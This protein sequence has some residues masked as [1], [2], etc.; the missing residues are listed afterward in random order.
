VGARDKGRE[1]STY[2]WGS[3]KDSLKLSHT[4]V[5]TVDAECTFYFGCC[6]EGKKGVRDVSTD[7][8]REREA[9]LTIF[10]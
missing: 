5:G 10:F 1:T 6:V 9:S 3:L 2:T 4:F 8:N 7:N